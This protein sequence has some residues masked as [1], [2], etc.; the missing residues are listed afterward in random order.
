MALADDN[1]FQPGWKRLRIAQ[2]FKLTISDKKRLLRG[3]FR[4]MLMVAGQDGDTHLTLTE[5]TVTVRR[6]GLATEHR[7]TEL[8]ELPELFA[9]LRVPITDDEMARLLPRLTQLRAASAV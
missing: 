1:A 9:R 6:P 7:R 3:I 5:S 2:L 8:D 4:Q